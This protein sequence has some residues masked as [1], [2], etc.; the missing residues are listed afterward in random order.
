MNPEPRSL[1]VTLYPR[2]W[3]WLQVTS[4]AIGVA[5]L[6][7]FFAPGFFV[8]FLASMLAVLPVLAPYLLSLRVQAFL[9]RQHWALKA[10]AFAFV[11]VYV[12]FSAKL[13]APA[14]ASV[15]TGL[16]SAL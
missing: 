7:F 13:L 10:A 6:L 14:T 15:L 8:P 16:R 2:N 5:L 11:I 4:G 1:N 9:R 12:R 3:L